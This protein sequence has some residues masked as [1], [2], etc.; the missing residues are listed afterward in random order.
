MKEFQQRRCEIH[1]FWKWESEL[2][3]EIQYEC[4]EKS[5]A[6]MRLVIKNLK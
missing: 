2:T 1:Y 4:Q 5:N 3:R 6:L